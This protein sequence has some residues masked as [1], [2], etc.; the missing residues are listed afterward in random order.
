MGW[1]SR[2][3]FKVTLTGVGSG[4]V[5]E[6]GGRRMQIDCE[7]LTKPPGLLIYIGTMKWDPPHHTEPIG[8]DDLERIK[9]NV[10]ESLP[11]F[12]LKWE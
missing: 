1:F 9:A 11:G 8:A 10:S 4:I 12:S 7:I 3:S 5:Y 2:K 6:E